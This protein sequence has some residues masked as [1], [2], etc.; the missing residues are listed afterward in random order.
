M[1]DRSLPIVEE[2]TKTENEQPNKVERQQSNHQPHK[3]KQKLHKAKHKSVSTSQ[4]PVKTRGRSGSGSHS[5]SAEEI[6]SA[7]EPLPDNGDFPR[8]ATTSLAQGS[9]LLF[10]T[11]TQ[12]LLSRLGYYRQQ[13][14]F[15]RDGLAFDEANRAGRVQELQTL[16]GFV[17][18]Y[19]GV[20]VQKDKRPDQAQNLGEL[21]NMIRVLLETAQTIGFAE[22]PTV[23]DNFN[24][25][26]P[27]IRVS[28]GRLEV[29]NE[30]DNTIRP[31]DHRNEDFDQTF[32]KTNDLRGRHPERMPG[33]GESIQGFYFEAHMSV[34]SAVTYLY[35]LLVSEFKPANF[36]PVMSFLSRPD[37]RKVEN[38]F[39][40]HEGN[41]QK[42]PL[43][44]AIA[45]AFGTKKEAPNPQS[46]QK[47]WYYNTRVQYL[48]ELLDNKGK[49]STAIRIALSMGLAGNTMASNKLRTDQAEVVR[50]VEKLEPKELAVFW[51]TYQGKLGGYL[52]PYNLQ[53]VRNYVHA[54]QQYAPI[55]ATAEAAGKAEEGEEKQQQQAILANWQASI[56]QEQQGKIQFLEQK[57]RHLEGIIRHYVNG[58][59]KYFRKVGPSGI[60]W[61]SGNVKDLKKEVA[62]WLKNTLKEEKTYFGGYP[63]IRRYV[64]GEKVDFFINKTNKLVI[65]A[66]GTE[67]SGLDAELEVVK[68]VNVP[69]R[70]T[71]K[72]I[73]DKNQKLGWHDGDRAMLRLLIAQGFDTAQSAEKNQAN[74]GEEQV[75]LNINEEDLRHSR[76]IVEKITRAVRETSTE[77]PKEIVKLLGEL[78]AQAKIKGKHTVVNR[79]QDLFKSMME[80]SDRMRVEF[81][82]LFVGTPI[83]HASDAAE[84]D[85]LVAEALG[86]VEKLL[87]GLNILP[88]QIYEVVGK[89]KYGS[90]VGD[91]YLKLRRSAGLT[92]Y[93]R[94]RGIGNWTANEGFNPA[95]TLTHALALSDKE[96]VMVRQ[97]DEMLL[98]LEWK[99]IQAIKDT[100]DSAYLGYVVALFQSL[101]RH[102]GFEPKLKWK[103]IDTSGKKVKAAREKMQAWVN[104]PDKTKARQERLTPLEAK[105]FEPHY[106]GYHIKYIGKGKGKGEGTAANEAKEERRAQEE[107]WDNLATHD[108]M[109]VSEAVYKRQIGVWAGR[110]RNAAIGEKYHEMMRMMMRVWQAGDQWYVP[111]NICKKNYQTN[112][113]IRQNPNEKRKEVFLYEVFH[114]LDEPAKKRIK[115]NTY[116]MYKYRYHSAALAESIE[117]L[118]RGELDLIPFI[119]KQ[120]FRWFRKLDGKDKELTQYTFTGLHGRVLLDEWTDYKSHKEA[121]AKRNG[122]REQMIELKQRIKD[123]KEP[124][125]FEQHKQRLEGLKEECDQASQEI[126]RRHLPLPSKDQLERLDG[127]N[128]STHTSLVLD[129]MTHL[130]DSAAHDKAFVDTLLAEGYL[131]EDIY[132]LSE[133]Y[134]GLHANIKNKSLDAGVGWHWLTA[135]SDEYKEGGARLMSALRNIEQGVSNKEGFGDLEKDKEHFEKTFK[136][137]VTKRQEGFEE[138]AKTYR[139]NLIRTIELVVLV[140]VAP[141]A[142]VGV[143]PVIIDH[144]V[145]GALYAGSGFIT[146]LIDKALD[147]NKETIQNYV[148]FAGFEALKASLT[149]AMYMGSFFLSDA[150][151][152]AK[153]FGSESISALEE[154]SKKPGELA[155]KDAGRYVTVG[156]ARGLGKEVINGLDHFVKGGA[157]EDTWRAIQD[158][159]FNP[160]SYVKALT[161]AATNT[162]FNVTG[163]NDKIKEGMNP[164][165]E[166]SEDKEE[167]DPRE[168]NAEF[169]ANEGA[170]AIRRYIN[171]PLGLDKLVEC[172]K[173]IVSNRNPLFKSFEDKSDN[174]DV[175]SLAQAYIEEKMRED[176]LQEAIDDLEA[177]V[178]MVNEEVAEHNAST[179]NKKLD[180]VDTSGIW[181]AIKQAK[182]PNF[183]QIQNSLYAAANSIRFL[184][185]RNKSGAKKDKDEPKEEVVEQPL[186]KSSE[187][188]PKQEVVEQ[189]LPK[190]S[191][192]KPKEEVVE[193]P[194]P[195]SSESKPKQEITLKRQ[196]A[197][198]WFKTGEIVI[199]Y[200]AGQT[201][202]FR[203]EDV[204]GDGHCLIRAIL[205]GLDEQEDNL[206]LKIRK[207]LMERLNVGKTQY[208]YYDDGTPETILSYLNKS[209]SLVIWIKNEKNEIIPARGVGTG[210]QVVHIVQVGNHFQTL[211]PQT[212]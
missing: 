52:S 66:L 36:F 8:Y 60:A 139:K 173:G 18:Q 135:K 107:H 131:A 45:K 157:N 152:E 81:L 58:G 6:K 87:V 178:A 118:D 198:K 101:S 120:G 65:P 115:R 207:H 64:L 88:K 195:K 147:P 127:G 16:L 19:M 5:V 209:V 105:D 4:Q 67:A 168:R 119:I 129:L 134:L 192:S 186:P 54:N 150:I 208:L 97:D 43:R 63:L 96:L 161:K 80:L 175:Q 146:A 9:N 70:H 74:E 145:V 38:T 201:Y 138:S 199:G 130:S 128:E 142:S 37:V 99:Y 53:R 188:K 69:K 137:D 10:R 68:V 133:N 177:A 123:N 106:L 57:D 17:S 100:G 170:R 95:K 203:A 140:G 111:G 158:Q 184:M 206:V 41:K 159:L 166:Q 90:D 25:E 84:A 104:P 156:M 51:Q 33:S 92:N 23:L 79:K 94:L 163:L 154:A 24:K 151:K 32:R 98:G 167:L 40:Y 193:Q 122:L 148:G 39:V 59:G 26:L 75:P 116:V 50:L 200:R 124:D 34:E 30:A 180:F 162:T 62:D 171:T 91:N 114:S 21:D 46:G 22:V 125:L 112:P 73:S 20:L 164:L 153:L 176:R 165:S 3:A 35:E 126:R 190:S 196:A 117:Q 108:D 197:I 121:L 61:L 48:Y 210:T 76:L 56:L 182:V 13:L 47:H 78:A 29:A 149:A 1:S 11:Y 181:S 31:A 82:S 155:V 211:H 141:F 28:K 191:E 160:A 44:V 2:T 14:A 179:Q 102:L 85:L 42:I 72:A 77:R 83:E 49:A 109:Q 86:Q 174:D 132:A 93:T 27:H 12:T 172:T 202:T 205:A 103:D 110:L 89:L 144:L 187:G 204:H 143:V 183:T 55:K 189:P 71:A 113:Y 15:L 194:L 169:R 7:P 185:R 212:P 136:D